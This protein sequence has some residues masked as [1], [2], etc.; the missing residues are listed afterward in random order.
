MQPWQPAE[1]S[2]FYSKPLLQ[3]LLPLAERRAVAPH[4]LLRGCDFELASVA[5][6]QHQIHARDW[7]RIMQ[8][9]EQQLAEPQLWQLVAD[10]C[11]NERLSPLVDVLHYAPSVAVA[12][13]QFQH[14]RRLLQPL[15]FVTVRRCKSHLQLQFLPTFM[16]VSAQFSIALLLTFARRMGID[17]SLWHLQLDSTTGALP[18]WHEWLGSIVDAPF[19]SLTLPLAQL[20]QP[21]AEAD[22]GEY[23]Q[24]LWF[25][26]MQCA[27]VPRQPLLQTVVRWL[28][29]R[30]QAADDV[31]LVE[32][33]S[34]LGIS[35]SSCKR[36][37]SKHGTT[38]QEVLDQVR[39]LRL[40]E[41][42]AEQP[43]SNGE[44]AEQLGYSNS[45]N[46]RR[47]CKRWLGVAPD[48]LRAG[49]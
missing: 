16:P 48:L 30:L 36:L 35:V 14:Y 5:Q 22:L 18:L 46:F 47:A 28:Q 2:Y 40:L 23:R 49:L 25:T 38:F 32:L 12:L 29:Q 6:R 3:A 7:Q 31:S 42:L 33:A 21:L 44:L 34:Y 1:R 27:I 26:R 11:F 19:C 41:L 43:Y 45:N 24:A 4:K 13:R 8:N 20:Q 17:T 39:L 37:L 15:Q 9:A 10:S